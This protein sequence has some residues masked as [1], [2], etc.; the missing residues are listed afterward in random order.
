[1]FAG[2]F[3]APAIRPMGSSLEFFGRRKNGKE[4]PLEVSL[5][6]MHTGGTLLAI[7]SIVD[8]TERR[9][10]EAALDENERALH[11][12]QQQL[13]ALTE[14]LITTQEKER[15][16]LARELHD[17]LN[18]RLAALAMKTGAVEETLP[19][20]SQEA[21]AEM[22]TCRSMLKEMTEDVRRLAHQL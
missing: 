15:E 17:D 22:R 5:S 19:A 18:Q 4:F 6:Y 8:L 11:L 16:H 12:S 14:S 10:I 20:S 2:Y 1:L 21:R 7:A 9:K 3:T 13:Q